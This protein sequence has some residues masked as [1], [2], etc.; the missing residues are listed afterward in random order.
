MSG[1][2][3]RACNVAGLLGIPGGPNRIVGQRLGRIPGEL[4]APRVLR[5]QF[6]HRRDRDPDDAVAV[7]GRADAD[8]RASTATVLDSIPRGRC[9]TICRPG[10]RSLSNP[11]ARRCLSPRIAAVPVP[12]VNFW[13]DRPR[14]S[15]PKWAASWW[16]RQGSNLGPPPCQGGALPLSYTPAVPVRRGFPTFSPPDWQPVRSRRSGKTRPKAS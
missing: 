12:L 14:S 15:S 6:R 8:P 4:G 1:A 9:R 13:P 16:A 5:S 10:S 2:S 11:C 7:H 3:R